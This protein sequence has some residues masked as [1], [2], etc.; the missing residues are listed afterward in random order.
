M[1]GFSALFELWKLPGPSTC[2]TE[3]T[4]GTLILTVFASDTN[5]ELLNHSFFFLS[6]LEKI[7]SGG[8]SKSPVFDTGLCM[9][10]FCEL[11]SLSGLRAFRK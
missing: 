10:L 1:C 8:F 6:L 11:L 2:A 5:T 9:F 4:A 3:L 7:N